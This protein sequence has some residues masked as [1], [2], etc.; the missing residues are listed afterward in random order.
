MVFLFFFFWLCLTAFK[1]ASSVSVACLYVN[2]CQ[3]VRISFTLFPQWRFPSLTVGVTPPTKK[4]RSSCEASKWLYSCNF[5]CHLYKR[6]ESKRIAKS[7]FQGISAV[8]H[9]RW[10]IIVQG[11]ALANAKILENYFYGVRLFEGSLRVSIPWTIL[12]LW[13]FWFTISSFKMCQDQFRSSK[14]IQ[15][16]LESLGG[17]SPE[18][19]AFCVRILIKLQGVSAQQLPH[20]CRC[21][22][23][24]ISWSYGWRKMWS[25]CRTGIEDLQTVSLLRNSSP[26]PWT[27][28]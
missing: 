3:H 13:Y 20:G 4:H 21:H 23:R 1:V 12:S 9:G 26:N 19:G 8:S 11:W 24:A 15:A 18:V 17:W 16:L 27:T 2:I 5:L 10:Q 7:N 14:T 6:Q 25:T 22:G 28:L